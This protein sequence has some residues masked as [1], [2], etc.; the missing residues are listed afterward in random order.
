MEELVV[1]FLKLCSLKSYEDPLKVNDLENLIIK[2]L[3]LVRK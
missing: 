2:V 3:Y 1:V